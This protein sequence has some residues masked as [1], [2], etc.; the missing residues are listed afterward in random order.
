[1]SLS[2]VASMSM[3]SCLD[4]VDTSRMRFFLGVLINVEA[5]LEKEVGCSVGSILE[6]RRTDESFGDE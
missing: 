2:K 5:L 6:S 3:A 1:M 4:G